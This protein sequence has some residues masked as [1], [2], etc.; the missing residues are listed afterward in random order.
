LNTDNCLSILVL[1]P[2]FW[3]AICCPVLSGTPKDLIINL[4]LE[5]CPLPPMASVLQSVDVAN[6]IVYPVWGK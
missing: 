4:I 5:C 3:W 1:S 2:V 6:N